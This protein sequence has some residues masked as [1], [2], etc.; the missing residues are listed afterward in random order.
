[1]KVVLSQRGHASA[2]TLVEV[3]VTMGVLGLLGGVFFQVLNSGLILFAKNS[4]VNS[5]HEDARQGINRLTRDIHASVSVPQLRSNTKELLVIDSA[6][7]ATTP[8]TAVYAPGVS[9]QNVVSGPNYVWSDPG[10][11]ALIQI[12]KSAD[13]VTP[14]WR[15]IVPLFGIE[16]DIKNASDTGN[17]TGFANVFL[18]NG[19]TPWA[20]VVPPLKNSGSFAI[21]YYTE[22]V[23]YVAGRG[24]YVPDPVGL[25]TVTTGAYAASV[26]NV[27][28]AMNRYSL[29]S[30]SYVYDENAG[31]LTITPALYV[32]GSTPRYRFEDG[33]LHLFKQRYGP[34][35]A[36]PNNGTTGYPVWQDIAS[37]VKYLSSPIPFY[38]PLN[39]GNSPNSRYVG[40]TLTTADSKTSNRKF[41]ATG[42][43][44]DTQIDYR[45]RI[46][47]FQ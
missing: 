44:L 16:D 38:I 12:E 9:F 19:S 11:A 41:L 21:T 43:L 42:S 13:S 15:L 4:A 31:T 20:Q 24:S 23:M 8:S 7:A 17:G 30:G 18:V 28:S 2:Y 5:A 27:S 10:S 1:M 32:T 34:T 46:T 45:S 40:V 47:L 39:S 25:Y 37:V 35:V 22:R 26:Y 33:E 29:R 14:G 6:P 3:M 36:H